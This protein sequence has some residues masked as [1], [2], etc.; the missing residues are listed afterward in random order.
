MGGSGSFVLGMN[1]GTGLINDMNP[2]IV[3]IHRQAKRGMGDVA[4]PQNQQDLDDNFAELNHLR[5][6]RDVYGEDMTDEELSRMARLFVGNNLA[7]FR[8]ELERHRLAGSHRN[9]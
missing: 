2:D 7:S 1:R 8:T 5:M 6:R 3:N 4:I 9:E